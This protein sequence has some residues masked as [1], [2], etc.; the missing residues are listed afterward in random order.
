MLTLSQSVDQHLVQ[1]HKQFLGETLGE[2]PLYSLHRIKNLIAREGI[3]GFNAEILNEGIRAL[4]RQNLIY[5]KESNNDWNCLT[6]ENLLNAFADI[7]KSLTG[8]IR[9]IDPQFVRLPNEETF[10]VLRRLV[11]QREKIIGTFERWFSTN[12]ERILYDTTGKIPWPIIQRL[13]VSLN[14]WITQ[15][16]NI[17]GTDIEEA[18][19][20]VAIEHGLKVTTAE[21]AWIKMGGK[22]FKKAQETS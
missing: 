12:Y 7:K 11:T 17:F 20:S 14:L 10:A 3:G 4:V 1:E 21:D 8:A 9:G 6:S 18:I 13:R 19:K 2:I 22:L 5:R 16:C 15:R